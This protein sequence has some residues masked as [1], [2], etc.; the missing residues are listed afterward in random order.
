MGTMIG[1]EC[2]DCGARE[3]FSCGTGMMGINDPE[4]VRRA[5]DG[6]LG[7]AMKM[8]LGGGVPDG[9]YAY[10]ENAYYECP[11]C[12]AIIAGSSVRIADGSRGR[13][14]YHARP[15]VCEACGEDF[16]FWDD[17]VPL[18][19]DDLL[20]RCRCKVESGC[21]KC[22]SRNARYFLANWD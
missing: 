16:D 8:L 6:S 5:G 18:S 9:W 3:T 12:G 4:L 14:V 19:E 17:T 21:P 10:R 11:E 20:N 1:W 13:L 7:P 22:E 15:D 2:E